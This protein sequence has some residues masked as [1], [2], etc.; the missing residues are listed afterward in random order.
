DY[1]AQLQTKLREAGLGCFEVVNASLFGLTLPGITQL[2]NNWGRQ[3]EPEIVVIYPTPAFY[4]HDHP[5]GPPGP[6]PS[7]AETAGPPWWTPRL[8]GRA[9]DVIDIPAFIQ[10]R[11]VASEAAAL[12]AEHERGWFYESVPAERVA[13]FERDLDTLVSAIQA[14]SAR[15]IVIT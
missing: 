15:P 5:P 7:P 9:E 3:F 4:L 2:W 14:A 6:P 1:P 12:E 10:R 13:L 8:R 11:R